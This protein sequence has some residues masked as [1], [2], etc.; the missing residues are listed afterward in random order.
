[1]LA[2][3]A[4]RARKRERAFVLYAQRWWDEVSARVECKAM[5]ATE[6]DGQQSSYGTCLD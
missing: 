4:D 3:D 6:G 5:R 2:A 1:M